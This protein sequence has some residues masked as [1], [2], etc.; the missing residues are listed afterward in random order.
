MTRLSAAL[1]PACRALTVL[2]GD[3]NFV[4]RDKDQR[5]KETGRWSGNSD[6]AEAADFDRLI[7]TPL[8]LHE[9]EQDELTHDAAAA[10]S[11]LDR[12]YTNQ[13]LSYQLDQNCSCVALE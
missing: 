2:V 8:E 11:R 13:H 12:C 10:R 9:W 3:F 7:G 5:V 1:Q 4:I 6:A